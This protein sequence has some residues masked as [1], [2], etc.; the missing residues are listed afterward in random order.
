MVNPAGVKTE[1]LGNFFASTQ[2]K[3]VIQAGKDI[4]FNQ[5]VDKDKHVSMHYFTLLMRYLMIQNY[6]AHPFETRPRKAVGVMQY[7][8]KE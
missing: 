2:P 5:G 3:Q 4:Y 1:T 7:L 6:E 8:H